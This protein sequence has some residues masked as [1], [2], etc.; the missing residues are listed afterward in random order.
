MLGGGVCHPGRGPWPLTGLQSLSHRGQG[1]PVNPQSS[2]DTD[3]VSHTETG[4]KA[5]NPEPD[6]EQRGGAEASPNPRGR[7][8]SRQTAGGAG[9][10]RAA[11]QQQTLSPRGESGQ[12]PPAP[13]LSEPDIRAP[14]SSPRMGAAAGQAPASPSTPEPGA[15]LPSPGAG[16]NSFPAGVTTSV[17]SPAS[18]PGLL[19]VASRPVP[20]LR[21]SRTFWSQTQDVMLSLAPFCTPGEA[22]CPPTVLPA[23][24]K[25]VAPSSSSLPQS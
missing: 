14:S 1:Q 10:S 7:A 25:A 5:G 9:P 12:A 11:G 21:P 6:R 8:D 20:A 23:A 3:R 16:R 24:W 22:S 18:G 2:L 4:K 13:P 15:S 19:T 17:S